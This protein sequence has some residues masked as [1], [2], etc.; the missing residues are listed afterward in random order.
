MFYINTYVYIYVTYKM[1][2]H[3]KIIDIMTYMCMTLYV[4]IMAYRNGEKMQL[5]WN[6]ASVFF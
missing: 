5:Y 4:Y 6:K 1:L 2:G 3:I